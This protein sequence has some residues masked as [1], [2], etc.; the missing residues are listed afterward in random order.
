VKDLKQKIGIKEQEIE[1]NRA[2]IAVL[3]KDNKKLK[4]ELKNTLRQIVSFE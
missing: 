2:E 1:T 3:T 4:D